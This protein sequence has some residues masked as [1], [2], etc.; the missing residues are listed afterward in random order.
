M[1]DGFPPSADKTE[2]QQPN[3]RFY[4]SIE[5]KQWK[6]KKQY[7]TSVTVACPPNASRANRNAMCD[8][9]EG[10]SIYRVI[11]NALICVFQYRE[12]E[13]HVYPGTIQFD[14]ICSPF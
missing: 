14:D 8:K 1:F 12:T 9:C 7:V 11:E 10:K 6:I 3:I 13:F 2:N 5:S 4:R